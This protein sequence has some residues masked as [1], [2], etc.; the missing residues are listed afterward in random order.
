MRFVLALLLVL[1]VSAQIPLTEP[2]ELPGVTYASNVPAPED[3][4]GHVIG[5]RHTR[6]DQ[7]VEYFEAVDAA[8]DRVSVREYGRTWEGRPLIYAVVASPAN[9]ARIDEIVEQNRQLSDAPES[10]SDAMLGEMPAVVHLHYAVHGNE[11]SGAEAALLV[12][13][14]LAAGQ[15]APVED[16]LSNTVVIIDPV[17]NPDGLDRFADWVNRNR[18]GVPTADPQDREHNEAWPNGRTNHY[19]FDL[20][21]DWLLVQ[22]PESKGRVELFH[23]FRP[24]VLIDVHEMGG[25]STF[26]F[27]PGV[28]SRNNPNT[29]ARTFDL[30]RELA[31]YH[32][33]ALD[34]IGS[35]YYTEE[36]FDDFYYGKGSTYPDVNGA[37]GVLFEQGSSR[38]LERETTQGRLTYGFGVMN[39]LAASLG[40]LAGAVNMR[41]R[42]LR[43]QRDFYAEADRVAQAMTAQAYV[44]GTGSSG[45]SRWRAL[46]EMLKR[47]RIEVHALAEPVTQNGQRFEPGSAFVVP[48]R[49][50]QARLVKAVF[51]RV[52]TF[53]DSLFYDVSTW[54]MPLAFNL[55]YAE[56]RSAG[57]IVGDEIDQFEP[58]GQM[59]AGE[60]TPYAYLI[61]WGG[62]YA[63]RTLG[64]LLRAGVEVRTAVKPFRAR[65][66]DATLAFGRGTLIVPTRQRNADATVTPEGVAAIVRQ[67]VDEDDARAFAT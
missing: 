37:V 2:F 42:L 21:R 64:R 9:V 12:L 35:L 41:E 26:F 24:Q 33:A 5:S 20:N 17:I 38:G 36:S 30:T 16:V 58:M 8:S 57:T 25:N 65:V 18:G 61:E 19:L 48:V 28:P 55:P 51:E 62:Y 45:H 54:T 13:Y 6:P 46:G 7:I 67:A 32:A 14:H 49:Q 52:R 11:A 34:R 3:V 63:P 56:V 23:T 4:I 60:G 22:H 29:P 50:K 27:Q 59:M 44:V 43:H 15:G 10:V 53:Q 40:T 1:P 39:Q 31:T 66:G 47:H